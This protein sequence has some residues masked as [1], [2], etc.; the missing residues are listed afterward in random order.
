MIETLVEGF[1]NS[2]KNQNH[3]QTNNDIT[4]SNNADDNGANKTMTKTTSTR[5]GDSNTKQAEDVSW[6]QLNLEWIKCSAHKF[7]GS[8]Y[9]DFVILIINIEFWHHNRLLKK[10][11]EQLLNFTLYADKHTKKTTALIKDVIS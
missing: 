5:N 2:R 3:L 7:K 4:A 8:L 6:A 1:E 9:I 10:L 11:T